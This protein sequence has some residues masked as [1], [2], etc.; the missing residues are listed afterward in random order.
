M[1]HATSLANG[2][3]AVVTTSPMVRVRRVT[4]PRATALA[5]YPASSAILRILAAVAAFTSGLFC[6]ARDTVG[7]DTRASRAMSLIE[8][9]LDCSR[10][11]RHAPPACATP[12]VLPP[13][14]SD[15]PKNPAMH[16]FAAAPSLLDRATIRQCPP[17]RTAGLLPGC[18]VGLWPAHRCSL[19]FSALLLR[20]VISIPAV[21]CSHLFPPPP[22]SSAASASAPPSSSTCSR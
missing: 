11:S 6:S 12:T 1:P 17:A 15:I 13:S 16:T 10:N 22:P 7:C 9:C 4:R 20:H 21:R 14:L 8:T 3:S 5:R 2:S 19:F 18:R